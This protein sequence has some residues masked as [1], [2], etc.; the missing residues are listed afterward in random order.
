MPQSSS[1]AQ[2][3]VPQQARAVWF[4]GQPLEIKVTTEQ[5]GGDYA[6]TEAVAAPRYGPPPHIHHREAEAST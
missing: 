3:A 6:V 5:T 4:F 2:G 1:H